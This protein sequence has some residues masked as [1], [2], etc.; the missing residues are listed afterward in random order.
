MKSYIFNTFIFIFVVLLITYSCKT[1]EG[2]KETFV[3]NEC[4][5]KNINE[6]SIQV[7]KELSKKELKNSIGLCEGFKPIEIDNPSTKKL[8]IEQF[9]YT[10]K[11]CKLILNPKK[12]KK[13]AIYY[14]RSNNLAYDGSNYD[15]KLESQGSFIPS[16]GHVICNKLVN[17]KRW[18]KVRYPFISQSE[19]LTLDIGGVGK[20]SKGKRYYADIKLEY[21]YPKLNYYK[22]HNHL[23]LFYMLANSSSNKSTTFIDKTYN[24]PLNFDSELT[25]DSYGLGLMKSKGTFGSAK[26][27]LGKN[28]T[29][30]FTYTPE[31][32][33]NGSLLNIHAINDYNMGINIDF[34]TSMNIKNYLIVTIS[35]SS[36]VYNIGLINNPLI[37]VLVID[38]KEPT[39]M[40]NDNVI[41]HINKTT[42]SDKQLG[43]CP[44]GF[45]AVKHKGVIKCRD[46]SGKI[47]E[48]SCKNKKYHDFS[49]SSEKDKMAWAKKCKVEWNNCK[50]LDAF[51]IAPVDNESCVI[52]YELNFSEKSII[53]NNNKTLSGRLHNLI[54]YDNILSDTVLSKIYRYIILQLL[55]L[56]PEDNCCTRP[57]LIKE[58]L[59]IQIN[60]NNKLL[61]N[62]AC[63]FNEQSICKSPCQC[64]DWSDTSNYKNINKACKIKVN[65]YCKTSGQDKFCG[66]LRKYKLETT[67]GLTDK[68]KQKY[69]GNNNITV[70][71]KINNIANCEGCDNK[72]NLLDYSKKNKLPMMNGKIIN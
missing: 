41:N 20:F 60:K 66:F 53:V 47:K 63:P 55:K 13:Y 42:K 70:P 17:K 23:A 19:L 49:K 25:Q 34:Q 43:T 38:S 32:N 65:K 61:K 27:I 57:S 62:K 54:I 15:M 3:S 67:P 14:W 1:C 72:V 71:P 51:E 44:D 50:E 18:K 11:G 58:S 52:D 4:L 31:E 6:G 22:F 7:K 68:I 12:N 29:I 48:A 21:Y 5:P 35:N 46:I 30:I 8:A 33:E 28:N 26:S 45:K 56:K 36:Y 10:G 59:P 64:V 24:I 39:L 40:I 37:F 69:I 16:K 9:K 2:F